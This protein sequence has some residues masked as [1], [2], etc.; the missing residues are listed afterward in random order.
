MVILGDN[1]I[2]SGDHYYETAEGVRIASVTTILDNLDAEFLNRWRSKKA[3]EYL[4]EH[5]PDNSKKWTKKMREELIQECIDSV[6]N[7][8]G[9]AGNLGTFVHK[10]MA[11]IISGKELEGEVPDNPEIPRLLKSIGTFVEHMGNMVELVA[12][13]TTVFGEYFHDGQRLD[14]AGTIDA[15]IK[16]D[17]RIIILDWKTTRY[18]QDVHAAQVAAYRWAWN[19]HSPKH[20]ITETWIVHLPKYGKQ[21]YT[22]MEVDDTPSL[23]LFHGALIAHYARAG[24]WGDFYVV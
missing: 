9:E 12:E 15:I 19:T 21:P 17:D 20:K 13:E 2:Q 14:Y 6:D 1:Y 7:Y 4:L 23:N 5:L 11:S 10:I 24:Q 18:I 16:I 3:L 22:I 8:V